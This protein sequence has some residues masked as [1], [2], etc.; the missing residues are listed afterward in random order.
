MV[1]KIIH[2]CWFGNSNIPEKE[3]KCIASWEKAFPGYKVMFWNESNVDLNECTFVKQAYQLKKYAF[4]SD[5]VRA[6]VLA[7]YGGIYLDTD[8]KVLSSFTKLLEK[9]DGILGFERR[10]F[11]GTAVIAT[12]P[13]NSSIKELLKYYQTHDFILPNGDCDITAN[14]T[15]LTDILREKGLILGGKRQHVE[16][17]EIFN[18]EVFYPKKLNDSDFMV[19]DETMAIHMCSNSWLSERERKR[20]NNKI[21]INIARPILIKCRIIGI[22]ILGKER[23]RTIENKLRNM[24]K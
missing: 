19:T 6:K 7:E 3:K 1:P 21:W 8:V 13:G 11:I 12:Q 9:Y 5:Y 24:L 23:I 16:T 2:Y 4:V 22:K 17:F 20:G 18:R 14:V 10:A 15:I